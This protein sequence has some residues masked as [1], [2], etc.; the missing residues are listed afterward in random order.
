MGCVDG[1][2]AGL[3]GLDALE[4]HGQSG[5][6]GAG[7]L[8][9]L[10]PEPHGREGRLDRVR[11]PQVDPFAPYC[12]ANALSRSCASTDGGSRRSG[13]AAS[14][15]GG[16]AGPVPAERHRQ[17]GRAPRGARP[18]PGAA[19]HRVAVVT[20]QCTE[21][22]P[23]EDRY[24]EPGKPR[25]GLFRRSR[26][27]GSAGPSGSRGR[28][29][30]TAPDHSGTAALIAPAHRPRLSVRTG[31]GRCLYRSKAA[32]VQRGERA[33]ERRR[34]RGRRDRDQSGG[35]GRRLPAGSRLR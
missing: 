17:R 11:G 35:E 23:E 30:A 14:L 12:W 25:R 2:P 9:H 28:S 33:G 27:A 34:P 1:P 5:H 10:R 26:V 19:L 22:E 20:M 24:Q 16:R 18:V 7:A 13:A 8:G 3:G 21:P 31:P 4:D 15:P 32:G 6:A 29:T